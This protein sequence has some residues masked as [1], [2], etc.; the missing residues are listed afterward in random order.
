M[1]A[2]L[3]LTDYDGTLVPIRRTPAAAHLDRRRRRLLRRVCALRGVRLGIV[4]GRAIKDLRRLVGLSGLLYIGNHGLEMQGPRGGFVH[5]V[6]RRSVSTL[7][8]IA[9]QLRQCLRIRGVLVESKR[10]SLSVHWRNIRPAHRRAFRDRLTRCLAP[11]LKRRA[12]RVTFGKRVVEV[13][14][15]T[16]WNKGSAVERLIKA[17]RIR[18]G[19]V[20]YVGDDRTDEDAF[21]VV[22]RYRGL[23]V[24]V[25]GRPGRTIA[26]L[27]L[28]S[29]LEVERLLQN[30]IAE[31]W[32]PTP[33]G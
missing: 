13:R 33:K 7:R 5:P 17:Y 6:A 20:I 11:W 4:S 28:K 26:R 30:L 22:N 23:S 10:L 8:R 21:R 18:P 32:K 27:R 24:C 25:G 29:P 2:L 1:C 16:T 12:V 19:S 14:P 9:R 3:V 15:P 31:R